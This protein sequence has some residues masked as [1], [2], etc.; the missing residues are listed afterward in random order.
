MFPSGCKGSSDSAAV[1]VDL[2]ENG[3]EQRR[4]SLRDPVGL[5]S[6]PAA[7]HAAVLAR[8]DGKAGVAPCL[9]EAVR[10]G[11]PHRQTSF[12][13]FQYSSNGA[14]RFPGAILGGVILRVKEVWGLN[15][16]VRSAEDSTGT[17]NGVLRTWLT[18]TVKDSPSS[19]PWGPVLRG[20]WESV[21]C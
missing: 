7:A 21:E 18:L 15:G 14:Q 2:T 8:V 10:G 5:C 13:A 19:A 4:P 6:G 3:T 20:R 16:K 12:L 9:Q 11:W 17:G 1:S